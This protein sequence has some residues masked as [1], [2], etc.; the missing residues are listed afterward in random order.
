MDKPKFRFERKIGEHDKPSTLD[1]IR[2]NG[3][4]G[5]IYSGIGSIIWLDTGENGQIN[6]SD[7]SLTRKI[8]TD[9]SNL[10]TIEGTRLTEEEFNN[11]H[12]GDSRYNTA[13][14]K[15]MVQVFGEYET[16]KIK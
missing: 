4:W 6:L 3:R 14:R 1:I 9:V 2:V 16:K 11:I 7:Y 8:D 15:Y 10:E 5:Q 13:E 12:G